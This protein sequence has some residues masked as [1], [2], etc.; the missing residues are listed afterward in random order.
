VGKVKKIIR[1]W[2]GLKLVAKIPDP[3]SNT[4]YKLLHKVK[5]KG[6]HVNHLKALTCWCLVSI[7]STWMRREKSGRAVMSSL[8]CSS[9]V[10]W[11]SRACRQ[12]STRVSFIKQDRFSISY[13]QKLFSLSS[14]HIGL[15]PPPPGLWLHL[16][17]WEVG[18]P[19]SDKIRGTMVKRGN[20]M[21]ISLS[22]VTVFILCC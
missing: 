10:E 6:K 7:C 21:E 18:G 9:R 17:D 14:M 4:D 11:D 12:Y 2:S 8:H 5:K 22:G 19:Q 13:K 1:V 3:D 20:K 15:I 16:H